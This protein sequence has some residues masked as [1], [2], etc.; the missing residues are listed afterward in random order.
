MDYILVKQHASDALRFARNDDTRCLESLKNY[1][2]IGKESPSLSKLIFKDEIKK[3]LDL[4]SDYLKEDILLQKD[5]TRTLIK[6][7]LEKHRTGIR[8]LIDAHESEEVIPE[9]IE[10]NTRM[11]NLY[12][13][14]EK[15]RNALIEKSRVILNDV[16]SKAGFFEK[17][18]LKKFLMK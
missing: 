13:R 8:N 3:S 16:T 12:P 6:E 2:K 14:T 4:T 18:R 10:F 5:R 15:I 7:F 1:Y 17:L 9:V 11:K